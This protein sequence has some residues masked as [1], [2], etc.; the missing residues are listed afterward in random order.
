MYNIARKLYHAEKV[1]LAM[2]YRH[3]D[4]EKKEGQDLVYEGDVNLVSVLDTATDLLVMHEEVKYFEAVLSRHGGASLLDVVL[5]RQRQIYEVYQRTGEYPNFMSGAHQQSAI[6]DRVTSYP[7]EHLSQPPQPPQQS[8]EHGGLQ[9]AVQQHE[10]MPQGGGYANLTVGSSQQ[11]I[12]PHMNPTPP[13]Q[14][15]PSSST[16]HQYQGHH[17]P[18]QQFNQPQY[19]GH[20]SGV[21]GYP[22]PQPPSAQQDVT[23]QS[24]RPSGVPVENELYQNAALTQQNVWDGPPATNHTHFQNVPVN[25]PVWDGPRADTVTTYMN[26]PQDQPH[27]ADGAVPKPV[28]RPR[29]LAA[30]QHSSQQAGR[31]EEEEEEEEEGE[32]KNIHYMS[33]EA[34]KEGGRHEQQTS[35]IEDSLNFDNL[36]PPVTYFDSMPAETPCYESGIMLSGV[37]NY[38][39]PVRFQMSSDSG[40]MGLKLVQPQPPITVPNHPLVSKS[41]SSESGESIDLYGSGPALQGKARQSVANVPEEEE[42]EEEKKP[43]IYQS[44]SPTPPTQRATQPTIVAQSSQEETPHELPTDSQPPPPPPVPS[45]RRKISSRAQSADEL[46][47]SLTSSSSDKTQTKMRQCH[48]GTDLKGMEG[49]G[50]SGNFDDH[51]HSPSPSAAEP[52]HKRSTHEEWT[53]SGLGGGGQPPATTAAAAAQKSSAELKARSLPRQIKSVDTGRERERERPRFSSG[54]DLVEDREPATSQ[55]NFEPET[56][57]VGLTSE[58]MMRRMRAAAPSQLSA[59]GTDKR[60]QQQSSNPPPFDVRPAAPPDQPPSSSGTVPL[61][62][63]SPAISTIQSQPP[64]AYESRQSSSPTPPHRA[65]PHQLPLS[66]SRATPASSTSQPMASERVLSSSHSKPPVPQSKTAPDQPPSSADSPTVSTSQPPMASSKSSSSNK[67]PIAVH[68]T[69]PVV[70]TTNAEASSN[71]NRNESRLDYGGESAHALRQNLYPGEHRPRE[72]ANASAS[73]TRPKPPPEQE[74]S[75]TEPPSNKRSGGP[76]PANESVDDALARYKSGGVELSNINITET[77]ECTYCTNLN[78]ESLFQCEICG[79]SKETLI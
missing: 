63:R 8:T 76:P 62:T 7:T 3:T 50:S 73:K 35:G 56:P 28:P 29:R 70:S 36:A 48:S 23:P 39:D 52:R 6:Q 69:A 30:Y 68:K 16:S 55:E 75:F 46:E 19:S 45:P 47:S 67:H 27:M 37:P 66:S 42:E 1:F 58:E 77:W 9:E 25:V 65:T 53:P 12:V 21:Y 40:P 13:P 14:V 20:G 38:E 57:V 17:H 78:D 24:N 43:W 10:K 18:Q 2:G 31:E 15:M 59:H 51:P 33:M 61:S 71:S 72:R 74:T 11:G 34:R 44:G 22:P 4:R 5:Q 64:T 54:F 79:R 49:W 41:V 26:L 32:L 60:P